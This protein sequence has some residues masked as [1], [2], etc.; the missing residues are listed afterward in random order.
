MLQ[1]FERAE[2]SRLIKALSGTRHEGSTYFKLL[3]QSGSGK[4]ELLKKSV[5]KIVRSD[6][7]LIY[8]DIT[9]DEFQSTSFFP[10]L[11]ETVY[12]P[13]SYHY[14]TITN[15]PESLSLSKYINKIFKSHRGFEKFFNAMT[16]SASAVPNVG[17]SISLIMD[18][19]I[20]ERTA[21]IDSMLFLYFNVSSM[22][23]LMQKS[24]FQYESMAF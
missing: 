23:I 9:V 14:N 5:E 4:T 6:T 13:F 11:L 19:W 3:G 2:M 20:Q 8:I 21:S 12:M 10:L 1:F 16:I 18:K 7:F 22:S 15:V 17:G 24:Y